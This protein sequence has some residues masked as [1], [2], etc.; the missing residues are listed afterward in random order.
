MR[1]W[2]GFVLAVCILTS[3]FPATAKE[4]YDNS[5]VASYQFTVELDDTF[6][7]PENNWVYAMSENGILAVELHIGPAFGETRIITNVFTS[8]CYPVESAQ[9]YTYQFLKENFQKI[10]TTT[11][12]P[13]SENPYLP[14][15]HP[16]H[17]PLMIQIV[18]KGTANESFQLWMSTDETA[19]NPASSVLESVPIPKLTIEQAQAAEDNTA[20]LLRYFRKS[21]FSGTPLEQRK[22]LEENEI[23]VCQKQM[24]NDYGYYYDKNIPYQN[25]PDTYG[26][27]DIPYY[28][29]NF[30][31]FIDPVSGTFRNHTY[32]V[33]PAGAAQFSAD[34]KQQDTTLSNN[35]HITF[36]VVNG[37]RTRD[38]QPIADAQFLLARGNTGQQLYKASWKTLLPYETGAAKRTLRIGFSIAESYQPGLFQYHVAYPSIA[39]DLIFNSSTE[40]VLQETILYWKDGNTYRF[41]A[42][43]LTCAGNF[44]ERYLPVLYPEQADTLLQTLQPQEPVPDNPDAGQI[45]QRLQTLGLFSGTDTGFDLESPFTRAQGAA[46]LVRLMGMEPAALASPAG[47]KFADVPAS[48]WAAPY[49]SYC[50][51]NGITNGTSDTTFSPDDPMTGAQYATL[52][53]RAAGYTDVQPDTAFARAVDTGLLSST[54]SRTL[55]AQAPFLRSGMVQLSWGAL[56]ATGANGKTMTETLISR[57]VVTTAQAQQARLLSPPQADSLPQGDLAAMTEGILDFS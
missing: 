9:P 34:T 21:R 29:Y 50:A 17:N 40:T 5:R 7:T 35:R 23:P 6:L 51:Q 19:T 44:V 22:E 26:Y 32:T 45:A 14:A 24:A 39:L 57:G 48:H 36:T 8:I 53:L 27:P 47:S 10:P 33:A 11:N 49:V 30:R 46:M 25:S 54:Q 13:R 1:K 43:Q 18:N 56:K 41:P 3:V 52:L 28:F 37:S 4:V 2:I 15:E 31:A 16:V 12:E 20:L 42:S 55:S 38:G